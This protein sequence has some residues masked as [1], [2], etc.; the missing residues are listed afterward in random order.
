[1]CNG[2]DSR[3]ATPTVATPP[4][5][6]CR[7]HPIPQGGRINADL[8]SVPLLFCPLAHDSIVL[9]VPVGSWLQHKRDDGH[10]CWWVGN[11]YK[12]AS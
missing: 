12:I 5:T 1:M 4:Q 9:Q 6:V 10:L 11:N 7:D 3:G 2:W 8:G